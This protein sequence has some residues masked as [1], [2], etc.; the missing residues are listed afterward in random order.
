MT[1][2]ATVPASGVRGTGYPRNP[3]C[4][5]PTRAGFGAGP[6][7]SPQT[8]LTATAASVPTAA[9]RMERSE[10]VHEPGHR[11]VVVIEVG[12][13]YHQLGDGDAMAAQLD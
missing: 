5:A 4:P 13:F 2:T 1:A 9:T 6:T 8:R 11:F 7:R 12:V 3:L 10:I